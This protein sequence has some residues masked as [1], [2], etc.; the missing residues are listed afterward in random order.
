M[1]RNYIQYKGERGSKVDNIYYNIRVNN[2]QTKGTFVMEVQS[3]TCV[4]RKDLPI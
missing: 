1:R 3:T 2:I 4:N